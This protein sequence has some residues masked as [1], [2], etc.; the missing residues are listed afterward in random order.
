MRNNK[1]NILSLIALVLNTIY[2]LIS[3]FIIISAYRT[4]NSNPSN[5]GGAMFV[6]FALPH[7]IATYIGYAVNIRAYRLNSSRLTLISA[8]VLLFAMILFIPFFLA[9]AIQVILLFIASYQISE[10][11]ESK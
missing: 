2:V 4:S 1:R 3:I 7:W 11:K 6:V 9:L 8:F 10:S 5:Q